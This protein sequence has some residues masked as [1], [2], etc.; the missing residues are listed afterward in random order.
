MLSFVH[1][2]VEQLSSRAAWS[3]I[4]QSLLFS[5]RSSSLVCTHTNAHTHTHMHTHTHTHTDTHTHTHTHTH[6]GPPGVANPNIGFTCQLLQWQK[7]RNAPP[8]RMRMYRMAPHCLHAPLLLV[9]I[10]FDFIQSVAFF[11]MDRL[12]KTLCVYYVQ[13]APHCQHAPLLLVS[14]S[15]AQLIT[16]FFMNRACVCTKCPPLPARSPAKNTVHTPWYWPTLFN[17]LVLFSTSV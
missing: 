11:S 8:A 10:T 15:L 16:C 5:L 14:M 1:R 9:S 6:F 13:N 4:H 3:K 12:T 7:R 17:V 2:C